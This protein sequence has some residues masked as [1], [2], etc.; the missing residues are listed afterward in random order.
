MIQYLIRIISL[1]GITILIGGCGLRSESI[2]F[3]EPDQPDSLCDSLVQTVD[4]A[5]M[6]WK[7]TPWGDKYSTQDFLEYVLPPSIAEEPIEYYWRW[8]IPRYIKIP[9]DDRDILSI[10]TAINQQI[11][12][13]TSPEDW[14]NP[15]MGYTKTKQGYPGKCNDRS[16]WATMSMRAFGIPAAYEFIPLWGSGNHG[17]SFCSVI[18]PN[19]NIIVYQDEKANNTNNLFAQKVPKIY[20]R[21]YAAQTNTAVFHNRKTESLPTL[22]SDFKILDVTAMHSIGQRDVPITLQTSIQSKLAYL[23]VFHPASWI[24]VACTENEGRNACFTSI[25]TGTDNQGRAPLLGEDIGAGILYLPALYSKDKVIPAANPIIVHTSEIREI[26][27]DTANRETI[28]LSRKFP[29]LNR[30]ISFAQ[31]MT[32]GVFEVAN[33]SDF[34]DRVEVHYISNTPQSRIQRA[35]IRLT[36]PYRYVRY[37]KY[38][39][40]FSIAELA[41]YNRNNI[42]IKGRPI[43]SEG[44]NHLPE[45]S[46][47]YDRSPLTYFDVN[48]GI[49]IWAGLAF[50]KPEYIEYLEF[51]PRNDDNEIYPGDEYELFY[52]NNKWTSLGKQKASSYSLTYHQVPKNALLWL[53]DLTKGKEERPFTYE[54]GKQIW[55]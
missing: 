30:I 34:S 53:R 48:G 14:H 21:M 20:R 27:A 55:W 15:L 31:Q 49:D 54:N 17:H 38:N 47:I 9:V 12:V 6:V 46:A 50:D 23:C 33:K 43:A 36:K 41:V 44:C 16:I 18:L 19:N 22:F 26:K 42:Q 2:R 10:A 13:R 1:Y 32:N 29:R 4:S 52:W 7:R 3:L 51:C 11:I 24:P 35:H 25:G 28:T 45:L 40:V 8:D 39:G 37:R 5:C